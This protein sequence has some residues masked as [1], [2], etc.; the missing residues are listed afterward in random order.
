VL[1]AL[2]EVDGAPLA[3]GPEVGVEEVDSVAGGEVEVSAVEVAAVVVDLLPVEAEED[4][5]PG[6][7]AEVNLTLLSNN[8]FAFYEV[9][10]YI[11]KSLVPEPPPLRI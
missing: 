7:A 10:C 2:P 8:E 6:D 1:V 9:L 11:Y 3:A 5:L 4:L